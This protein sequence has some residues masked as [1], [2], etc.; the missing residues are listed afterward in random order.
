MIARVLRYHNTLE[1]RMHGKKWD[2]SNRPA[3]LNV[4]GEPL[5]Y[6][7]I[8]AALKA[9]SERSGI[10]VSAH[11]LRHGCAYNIMRSEHGG[12]LS[13]NL[14]LIQKQ[15]GHSK[16]TTTERYTQI[17]AILLTKLSMNPHEMTWFERSD[18]IF[19]NTFLPAKSHKEKRGH[20][21][22]RDKTH[23]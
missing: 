23:A 15:F 13:S 20:S 19:K 10:N 21:K 5:T 4:H 9:A 2:D 16:V 17:P 1:Y 7:A 3:F 6:S 8:G 12:E 22:I 14:V 11:D 18:K